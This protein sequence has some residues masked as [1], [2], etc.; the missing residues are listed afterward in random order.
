MPAALLPP[1]MIPR[2]FETGGCRGENDHI[3][4]D[5]GGGLFERQLF[6][7][8]QT[9]T[10]FMFPIVLIGTVLTQSSVPIKS[11]IT[12]NDAAKRSVR[13]LKASGEAGIRTLGTLAGT[14]VFET[15]PLNRKSLVLI[16]VLVRPMQ[17]WCPQ[18][19]P[20]QSASPVTGVRRAAAALHRGFISAAVFAC[21]RL[22]L[23]YSQ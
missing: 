7:A 14:L 5:K 10:T 19:C 20:R 16:T 22:T 21:P 12:T 9:S 23:I 6:L 15:S 17:P 13:A 3:G 8:V 4:E 2:F 1:A 18:W 11:G